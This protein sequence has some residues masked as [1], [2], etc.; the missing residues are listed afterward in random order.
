MTMIDAGER[1]ILALDV[2][3]EAEAWKLVDDLD[4]VVSFF[5]VGLELFVGAGPEFVRRLL[6]RGKKVFL[7]LKFNDV[8]ETVERAVRRAAG[9]G[10]SFLTIHGTTGTV[11]AAVRGR[12]ATDLKLLAVTVLT[13]LD[14]DDIRELGYACPVADLVLFR[15][16]AALD[17]GCD[18]VISSGREAGAIREFAGGRLLI[19]TPGIRPSDGRRDDHKRS[20]SPAEAIA[21]GAD[22]LVIGRPIR[23]APDRRGVASGVVREMQG[24]FD[25]RA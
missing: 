11:R 10:V 16:R 25:A 17:A 9:L 24:A 12:G 15:A 14:A 20:V 5:K 19:V 1:L 23:D 21:A 2:D 3:A 8:P 4:G 7:D 22:Y 18:G 6:D 13:S